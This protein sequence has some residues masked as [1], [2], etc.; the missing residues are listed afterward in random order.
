VGFEF[1]DLDEYLRRKEGKTIQQ[2]IDS[3]G[4]AALLE[5]EERSMREI[6]IK[7]KV[8]APGGSIIYVSELMESLKQSAYLIFLDDDFENI[9]KRLRNV[10]DR[11][12]VGLKTR[13]LLDIYNER[14]PLYT[15]YADITIDVREKSKD[16]AVSEILK[17]IPRIG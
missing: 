1:I 12:I 13:S 14:R 17:R 10:T 6:D 3:L 2:I 9:E 8:I 4:E 16:E 7:N 11:G 5:L 15:W